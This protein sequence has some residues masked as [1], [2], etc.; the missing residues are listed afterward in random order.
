MIPEELMPGVLFQELS[1]A[2]HGVMHTE[3]AAWGLGDLGAPLLLYALKHRGRRA[4]SPPAELSDMLAFPRHRRGVPEVAG[5][6]G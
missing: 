1:R 4:R 2:R 5:S 6:G 3:L